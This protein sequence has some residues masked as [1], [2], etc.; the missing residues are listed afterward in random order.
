[1]TSPR[2]YAIENGLLPLS[3]EAA[4]TAY[5]DATEAFRV[6]GSRSELL[7]AL[8]ALGVSTDVARWHAECPG[9]RMVAMT[10]SDDV[11]TL[12]DAT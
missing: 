1:M 6:G 3:N 10:T 4:L 5:E 2:E 12:A 11:D 7:R 9:N 8:M